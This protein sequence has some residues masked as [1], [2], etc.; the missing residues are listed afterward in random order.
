MPKTTNKKPELTLKAIRA[1]DKEREAEKK[2]K[3][4]KSKEDEKY[5]EAYETLLEYHEGYTVD[6]KMSPFCQED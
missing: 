5:D 3:K 1:K 4:K 2:K 6:D